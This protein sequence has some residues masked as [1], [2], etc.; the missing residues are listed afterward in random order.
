M[1]ISVCNQKGGVAKTTTT[2]N[3]GAILAEM[4][5]NVLLIDCDPQYNMTLGV[6]IEGEG[7]NTTYDLLT[8]SKLDIK[9]TVYET[10]FG[11]DIIPADIS[12]ANAEVELSTAISR[13]YILTDKLES[14]KEYYDYIL[15]DCN[16]ALGFL[17]V[18][19]LVASD[20]AIIPAPAGEFEAEGLANLENTIS[21][22]KKRLNPKLEVLGILLAIADKNTNINKIFSSDLSEIFKDKLFKTVIHRNIKIKEAQ[23]EHKPI[24]H[25]NKKCKGYQE[26]LELAKE[27]VE[28][29]KSI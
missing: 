1:V 24:N 29:G 10:E 5:H 12:L 9:D 18:N 11:F 27:I 3:V 8:D 20:K 28:H 6:N 19:A 21:K 22:V 13:E 14:I 25:Y 7:K 23:K 17:T 16:P 26:Y 15:I 2:I 4:G